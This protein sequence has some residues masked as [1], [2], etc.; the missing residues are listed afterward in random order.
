MRQS[1]QTFDLDDVGNHELKIMVSFDMSVFTHAP[2]TYTPA[3]EI[4]YTSAFTVTIDACSPL[5][6]DYNEILLPSFGFTM[7]EAMYVR[8][9]GD[10]VTNY[11]THY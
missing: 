7:P 9:N 5:P 11:F 6:C 4:L 8:T 3:N 10:I 1:S 2:S